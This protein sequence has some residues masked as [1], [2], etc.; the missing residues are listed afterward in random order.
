MSLEELFQ[1]IEKHLVEDKRP[2][3]YLDGQFWNP[4]FRKYPF[5]LL[6]KMK[7]T[8]QSRKFHPEGNVWNH[9]MLVVDEAAKIRGRSR[10]SKVF[11]WAA[12]LHDIGKPPTTK[13]K[14]GRIIS[15]N[16][17]VLGEDL[18]REFLLY[19]GKEKDFID[20]ICGLV[21]YHMQILLVTKNKQYAD[22]KGMMKRTNI[23][24][25]ALLG[26][27]DRLGRG[28]PNREK[29]IDNIKAFLK[30]C[31]EEEVFDILE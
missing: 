21:R 13:R 2:S 5:E 22:I 19:F 26:M 27:C 31:G 4:L 30:A 15:Y 9:T 18:A 17:D 20:E 8:E 12:L 11:M 25:L 28:K 10:N 23:R 16:H 14:S 24:E 1:E 29:E 7:K 3:I 6:Y